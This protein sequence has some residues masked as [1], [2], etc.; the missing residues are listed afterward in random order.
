MKWC[1][2]L[3]EFRVNSEE[4][5]KEKVNE[6]RQR[7]EEQTAKGTG[8]RKER[9][10]RKGKREKYRRLR[11]CCFTTRKLCSVFV[12][13]VRC[14]RSWARECSSG[15]WSLFKFR[16]LPLALLLLLRLPWPRWCSASVPLK[17]HEK[18][19]SKLMEM[20]MRAEINTSKHPHLD[21]SA[22][23]A[24]RPVVIAL[25]TPASN[26][27]MLLSTASRSSPIALNRSLKSESV[28]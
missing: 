15:C 10:K 14:V 19:K 1:Q 18:W 16:V 27:V 8:S 5:E 3:K 9:Q 24:A 26:S 4:G 13:C 28:Y 17:T 6:K 21:N 23:M 11:E 25:A 20:R 22:T 2:C 12:S 7:V